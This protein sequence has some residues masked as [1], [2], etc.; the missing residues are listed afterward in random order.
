MIPVAELLNDTELG[1]T[2]FQVI[3]RIYHQDEGELE[4]VSVTRTQAIGCI[5][6]AGMES[7]NLSPEEDRKETA[8]TIYTAFPL[9]TGENQGIT[10]QAAD[11]V[12]WNG[13]LY[14]V[15]QVKD[16]G[17]QGFVKGTAILEC[18]EQI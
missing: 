5:H 18:G 11:E 16:W 12:L 4:P 13:G 8:I 1:G 2:M 14:R 6:P 17:L 15:T 7:L 9:C 10:W 3:R